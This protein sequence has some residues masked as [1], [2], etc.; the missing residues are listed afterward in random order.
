[1]VSRAI[2]LHKEDEHAF[3]TT[4]REILYT[5]ACILRFTDYFSIFFTPIDAW[6]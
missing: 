3:N 4:I 1:M 6:S 2:M 5:Y